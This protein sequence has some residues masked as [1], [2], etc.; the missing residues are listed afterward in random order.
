MDANK[1]SERTA[2]IMLNDD[3][4]AA[5]DSV[6]VG[7]AVGNIQGNVYMVRMLANYYPVCNFINKDIGLALRSS[8]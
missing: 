5:S 6:A 2:G 3:A 8:Q 7:A 4:S 1:V